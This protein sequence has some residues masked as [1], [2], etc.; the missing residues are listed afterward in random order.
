MVTIG[1]LGD[2]AKKE[3]YSKLYFDLIGRYGSEEHE[4]P[5]LHLE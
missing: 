2:P 5:F 3:L 4:E 1:L